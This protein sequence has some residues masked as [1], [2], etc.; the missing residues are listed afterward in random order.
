MSFILLGILNAQ[1]AGGDAGGA[2]DLLETQ[3]L[4]SSASSVTF[5]GLDTL[6]SGYQHLQLRIVA[7]GDSDST[8]RDFRF[9]YNSDTGANYSYHALFGNS[10]AVQSNNGSSKNLGQ[11][12]DFFPA[13]KITANVFGASIIDILDFNSTTKNKTMRAFSGS[14]A[15]TPSGESVSPRIKLDSALWNSTAAITSFNCYLETGN[16]VTGSRFSLYGIRGE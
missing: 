9:N 3:I 16:F 7:R 13:S 2:Y 11:I 1:A 4:T 15:P 8:T 6:A 14:P 10:T 12:S 5:T